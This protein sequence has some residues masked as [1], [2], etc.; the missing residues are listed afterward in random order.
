MSTAQLGVDHGATPGLATM[1]AKSE[2]SRQYKLN[3]SKL[4]IR[5][6]IQLDSAHV[7]RLLTGQACWIERLSV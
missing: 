3:N 1:L 6:N 4:N 5:P 7:L 2:R